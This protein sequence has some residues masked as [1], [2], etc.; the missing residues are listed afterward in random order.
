MIIPVVVAAIVGFAASSRSQPRTRCERK[1]VLGA[2][3]GRTYEVEEFPE[4][5][6][7][8]VRAPDG[9]GVFQHA[10]AKNPGDPRFSWRG[11]K[12]PSETL[13]GMCLDLGIVREPSAVSRQPSAQ[14]SGSGS[15]PGQNPEPKTQD[16]SSRPRPTAVPSPSQKTGS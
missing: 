16:P 8:I 14:S 12:G 3:T 6:F 10:T 1:V 13:H 11:G 7:L 4:A 5:G 15:A 2:R 9:Y